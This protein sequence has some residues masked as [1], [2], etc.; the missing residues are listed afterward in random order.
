MTQHLQTLLTK[1]EAGDIEAC[2]ELEAELMIDVEWYDE[3]VSCVDETCDC[4]CAKRYYLF[5]SRQAAR[6]AA[7]TSV[8]RQILESEE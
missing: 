1:A 5:S 7:S 8:A 2:A 4:Y 3:C 6:L